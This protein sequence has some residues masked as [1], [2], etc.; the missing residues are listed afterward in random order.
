MGKGTYIV[1]MEAIK[2]NPELYVQ[3]EPHLDEAAINPDRFFR[4][5][6]VNAEIWNFFTAKPSKILS[7]AV[8]EFLL[9]LEESKFVTSITNPQTVTRVPVLLKDVAA[10]FKLPAEGETDP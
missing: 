7:L 2:N 6:Q 8:A 9:N 1:T 10:V 5:T 3:V 4:R